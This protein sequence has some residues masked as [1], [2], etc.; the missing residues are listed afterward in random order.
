MNIHI[1]SF[2]ERFR[3]KGGKRKEGDVPAYRH[4][5]IILFVYAA[6]FVGMFVFAFFLFSL[7]SKKGETDQSSIPIRAGIIKKADVDKLLSEYTEKKKTFE[8]LLTYP[9]S[10]VDPSL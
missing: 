5:R 6:F 2:I 8:D 3:T 10:F 9:P 4:W 1:S 7:A